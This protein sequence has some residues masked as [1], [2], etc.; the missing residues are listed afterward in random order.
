MI[1][2]TE[3][4]AEMRERHAREIARAV[5]REHA[6]QAVAGLH[7]LLADRAE[8]IAADAAAS[9]DLDAKRPQ[10]EAF[11]AELRVLDREVPALHARLTWKDDALLRAEYNVKRARLEQLNRELP[12]L[13]NEVARLHQR[14]AW[15]GV[16]THDERI[17]AYKSDNAA[18][19]AA[20]GG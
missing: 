17:A 10:L 5:A 18:A 11:E 4:V 7:R 16:R 9:A 6:E 13:R 12:A 1:T 15:N 19:L 3:T 14:C 2:Q 20:A 8:K